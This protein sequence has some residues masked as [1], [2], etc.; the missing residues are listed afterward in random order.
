MKKCTI[1]ALSFVLSACSAIPVN[2]ETGSVNTNF[3]FGPQAPSVNKKIAIVKDL[4]SFTDLGKSSLGNINPLLA[5]YFRRQLNE[6]SNTSSKYVAEIKKAFSTGVETLITKKGFTYSGPYDSF[7]EITYGDKKNSYLALIPN[8]DVKVA[9][10][11]VEHRN[12][13]SYSEEKGTIKVDGDFT[14]KFI[15]PLTGQVMAQKRIDLSKL[16]ISESYIVQ[17]ETQNKDGLI[18]LAINATNKPTI[19]VDNFDKAYAQA[20]SNFYQ[21]AMLKLN[22][23]ISTE[24]IMSFESDIRELKSNKRY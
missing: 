10:S 6:Q 14:I 7:D 12:F 4:G 16:N 11:E 19:L 15:E 2:K 18:G 8:F 9:T 5:E 1:L 23:Y 17:K 21:G 22:K 24:E 13:S 20:M 3:D